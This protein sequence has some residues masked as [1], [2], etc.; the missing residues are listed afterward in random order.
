MKKSVLIVSIPLIFASCNSE[1]NNQGVVTSEGVVN[2]QTNEVIKTPEQLRE[3]LRQQELASPPQY[4]S[5]EKPTCTENK[6]LVR[7]EGIFNAAEYSTDGYIIEG[8]IHNKASIAAYKDVVLS[9]T[10]YSKTETAISTEEKTIYEIYSP[11]T[12]TSFN[13]KVYPPDDFNTFSVDLKA[14]IGTESTSTSKINGESTE[15]VA[16]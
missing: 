10:F 6:V 7:K 16:H 9:I 4:L 11:N 14:A 12:N 15:S 2:A 13:L 3:D 8:I 1:N 5:V